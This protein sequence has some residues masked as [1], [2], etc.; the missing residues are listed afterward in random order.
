MPVRGPSRGACLERS[1]G[2]TP[3]ISDL[4]LRVFTRNWQKTVLS[5]RQETVKTLPSSFSCNRWIQIAYPL[6]DMPD[7]MLQAV[8]SEA[9]ESRCRPRV[10]RWNSDH[11]LIP[12]IGSFSFKRVVL[13]IE[14]VQDVARDSGYLVVKLEDGFQVAILQGSGRNELQAFKKRASAEVLAATGKTSYCLDCA[15]DGGLIPRLW[16][17]R[18]CVGCREPYCRNPFCLRRLDAE[19]ARDGRTEC[20]SCRASAALADRR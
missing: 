2:A 13:P 18:D 20:R 6:T 3:D 16:S 15:G 19:G 11:F 14:I 7:K 8:E 10:F 17:G 12:D 5:P 4:P 9:A 1:P